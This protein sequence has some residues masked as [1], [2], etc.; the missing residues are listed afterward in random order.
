MVL[1]NPE[2]QG[3]VG[4]Q[5]VA[6]MA[7]VGRCWCGGGRVGWDVCGSAFASVLPKGGGELGEE[8]GMP[9]ELRRAIS[10]H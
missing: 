8:E 1:Q 2:R 6:L 7:S 5:A 10:S 3:R 4:V 9:V